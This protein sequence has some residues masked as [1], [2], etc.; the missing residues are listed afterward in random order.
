MSSNPII[1]VI[2]W[3]SESGAEPEVFLGDTIEQVEAAGA[4]RILSLVEDLDLGD[5]WVE[6]HPTPDLTDAPAVSAWL[7]AL[8]EDS[9]AA[10]LTIFASEVRG[11]DY[12]YTD[13]RQ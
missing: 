5:A 6:A 13:L 9:T 10:W 1:G 4:A 8:R 11:C 2:E 12:A 3:S 7:A